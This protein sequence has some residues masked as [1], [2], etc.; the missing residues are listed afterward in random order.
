VKRHNFVAIAGAL[1]CAAVAS[2]TP[3]FGGTIYS[4]P[5][6]LVLQGVP[7]TT[8]SLTIYLAGVAASWDT[9]Q[10]SISSNSIASLG[11]NDIY[12]SAG[13]AFATTASTTPVATEFNFGDPYP[14]NP[15]F[16]SGSEILWG[17]GAAGGFTDGI[18]YAALGFG[19]QG[20][21][22]ALSGWIQLSVQNSD[23]PTATL[24]VI[25]WAYS[26]VVGQNI[27]MEPEVPE[28]STLLLLALSLIAGIALRFGRGVSF[29]MP[30]TSSSTNWRFRSWVHG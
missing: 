30:P 25:D 12:S 7:D 11:T 28:P 1:A 26:D 21:G 14:S 9:L 6:D 5:Q 15:V 20:G 19:T 10:L 18:G 3:A 8:Q 16:A 29:Q 22:P 24:T 2:L 17:N 27:S 23:L 4:G 13:V